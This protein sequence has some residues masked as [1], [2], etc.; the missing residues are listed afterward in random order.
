M[1]QRGNWG[2]T[3]APALDADKEKPPSRNPGG[4]ME[5]DRW[6]SALDRIAALGVLGLAGCDRQPHLLAHSAG[7]EPAHRVCLPARGFHE[8]LQ[9][10]S[11]AA[12]EQ[13]EHLGSLGAW[14][15]SGRLSGRPGGRPACVG[16]LRRTGLVARPGPDRRNVGPVCRDTRPFGRLWRLGW[17]T[18]P[19]VGGF[20]CNSVHGAFSFGGSYSDPMDHSGSPASQ[21]N[22]SGNRKGRRIGDG[23]EFGLQIAADGGRC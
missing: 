4:S 11:A 22:S 18:G 6:S 12:P 17:G 20:F 23:G 16:L 19:R 15:G 1:N 2:G 9:R 10:G 21:A 13:A 3:A 14:P 5:L 8:F 7:Q